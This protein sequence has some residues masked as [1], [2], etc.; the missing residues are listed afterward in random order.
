MPVKNCLKSNFFGTNKIER[1]IAGSEAGSSHDYF[2]CLYCSIMME[3][4]AYSLDKDMII[5]FF[6]AGSL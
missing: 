6:Q 3:D 1:D 2:C 5:G 4:C